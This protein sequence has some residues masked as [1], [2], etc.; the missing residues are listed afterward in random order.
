MPGGGQTLGPISCGIVLAALST[1]FGSVSAQDVLIGDEAKSV[2]IQRAPVPPIIDGVLNEEIWLR[3]P[4]VDDLHQVNPVEFAEP[5]ERTE[6]YLLYDRDALYIGARM[7]D[8]EPE[9]IN[10]RI[11]RQNQA[12]G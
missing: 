8:S 10:A 7:Y 6:V 9:R 3:S 4:V 2:R 5:S 1:T 11:L 12:I